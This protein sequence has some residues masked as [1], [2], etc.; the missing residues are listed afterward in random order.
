MIVLD[1][2]LPP[3]PPLSINEERSMHWRTRRARTEPWKVNAFWLA[4]QARLRQ[5]VA[6]QRAAVTA[7]LPVHGNYERDPANFYPTVKAIV[8]G[9]VL[10]G[11]WPKDTPQYVTVN[12]P[13]LVDDQV[14]A[15]AEVRLELL[16]PT[17]GRP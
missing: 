5:A 9:L 6:G 13:I 11:V 15:N 3:T 17:G 14:Q 1:L 12:E 2:G 8:D 7:H 4:K 16:A 10:A